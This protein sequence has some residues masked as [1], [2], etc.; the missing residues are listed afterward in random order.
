MY[1]DLGELLEALGPQ[2]Q[3]F[4]VTDPTWRVVDVWMD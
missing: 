3:E 2:R 4:C 1:S